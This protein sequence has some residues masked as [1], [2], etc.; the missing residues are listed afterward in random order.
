MRYLWLILVV[1]LVAG[2]LSLAYSKF[3]LPD[4]GEAPELQVEITPERIE[5]GKYLA[6]C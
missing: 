4:T 6:H 2:L 3:M 5:C 1:L